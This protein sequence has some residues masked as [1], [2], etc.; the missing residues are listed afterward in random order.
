M[1]LT[2][3]PIGCY[4]VETL[5]AN[6]IDTVYG[7]P[8][9]HNLEL[10]RGLSHCR[11][12]QH[13][14]TRH[15]QNA[16]F[17][18]DGHAR[19][20][21]RP[22]GI[23]VISGP[24]V[25]NVLTAAAQAYSDSVPMLIVAST[26]VSASLGRRWGML[27]EMNDQLGAVQ[28]VLDLTCTAHSAQAVRDFLRRVFHEFQSGRPRPAYLGVPLDVLAFE[29]DL[30]PETFAPVVPPPLAEDD[31]ERAAQW[32]RQAKRPAIIAGGGA[33]G[34]A[35]ELRELVER[36]D[37]YCVTTAAGK[38]LLPQLHRGHLGASL[39]FLPTQ[40]LLAEADVVLAVGTEIAESDIYTA[41]RLKLSGDL[42]QIDIAPVNDDRYTR[43]LSIR[44]DARAAVA[45]IVRRV[46]SRSGWCT[47]NGSAS[48][49]HARIEAELDAP[50]RT[51][52]LAI[53]AIRLALPPDAALFSDMTQIAYLGNYA[54]ATDAPGVWHHPAGFGT[55]GYAMPAAMGAKIAMPNRA[56]A[57]LVGDF[58]LQYTL[59]ELTT[60]VE[61]GLSLPVIV[62]NNAALGQIRDDMI[63]TGIAPLGVIARNPDF[64]ALANA[65]GANAERVKTAA[66]LTAAIVKA[67]THPGPTVIE[68][69]AGEFTS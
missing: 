3:R 65:C 45:A 63:A 67:L 62:W 37:A 15:E 54:F 6:G 10:Y 23:F 7:I 33:I 9:V 39:P 29:T 44:G 43:K 34:A 14:L 35:A 17:A 60:A 26:P 5:A 32:L 20:S 36:L 16:G 41:N 22:A 13:I 69:A 64:L 55:L 42:I 19:A 40:Q 28:A 24:G 11:G 2:V 25:T 31:I 61:L 49:H 51:R 4:I 59:Q 52:R 18:A 48:A 46:D 58:G 47:A 53:E 21:R 12:L 56:V 50:S 30:S 27:H 68:V 1:S 38:G 8:G 66:A 57:A